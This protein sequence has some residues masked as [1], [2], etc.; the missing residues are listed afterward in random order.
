MTTRPAVSLAQ[1]DALEAAAGG[2]VLRRPDSTHW[3]DTEAG[4]DQGAL[5]TVPVRV[6]LERGLLEEGPPIADG[7]IPVVPTVAGH[8]LLDDLTNRGPAGTA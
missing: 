7:M 1:L 5:L 3:W 6:L 4:P 2:T 8:A